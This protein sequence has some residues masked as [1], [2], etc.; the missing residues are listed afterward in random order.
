MLGS[1]GF[2]ADDSDCDDTDRTV[3]PDGTDPRR[4]G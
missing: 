1:E 4:R 3:N 2:V